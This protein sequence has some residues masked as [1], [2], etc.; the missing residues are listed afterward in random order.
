[1]SPLRLQAIVPKRAPISD[2]I[3]ALL[4]QALGPIGFQGAVID[5]LSDYPE[6]RPWKSR[7]PTSGPRRGGRRTGTLGRNWRPRGPRLTA[8]GLVTEARNDTDYAIH[9]QGPP[10]G[11][12]GRRQTKVMRDRG[13]PNVTTVGHNQWRRTHPEVV[14]ILTQRDRR[15]RFRNL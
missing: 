1:M 14:R 4:T 2:G 7:P 12:K 11:R 13:W 5:D 15:L 10:K 6:A 3:R 9:V 8:Q